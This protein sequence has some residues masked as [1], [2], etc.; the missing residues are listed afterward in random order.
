MVLVECTE[1]ALRPVVAVVALGRDAQAIVELFGRRGFLVAL[2][3]SDAQ[4]CGLSNAGFT[5]AAVVLDLDT[6]EGRG[7]LELV[8]GL[9]HR[10]PVVGIAPDAGTPRPDPVDSL[11]VRPVD[12]AL[13]FVH[14]VELIALSRS[15]RRQRKLSGLV[16][17]V[18]GNELFMVAAHQLTCAV[19]AVNAS[20][21]LEAA[22]RSCGSDPCDV[23]R[24]QLCATVHS[25]QLARALAPFASRC[26][27]LVALERVI[28]TTRQV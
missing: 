19:P 18:P 5:P 15:G 7:A 17:A 9:A 25:G 12:P 10:P 21:I 20:A 24:S 3:P 13:L 22:L 26:A 27:I 4:L 16:G 23:D 6:S 1:Q 14:V 2:G 11:F 8:A 28:A